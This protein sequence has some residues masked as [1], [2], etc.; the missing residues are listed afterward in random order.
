MTHLDELE[1]EEDRESRGSKKGDGRTRF[2]EVGSGG[3]REG[4]GEQ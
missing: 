2:S 4:D 1:G 3:R